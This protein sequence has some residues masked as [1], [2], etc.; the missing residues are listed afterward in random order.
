M[1]RRYFHKYETDHDAQRGRG[2]LS[3]YHPDEQSMHKHAKTLQGDRLEKALFLETVWARWYGDDFRVGPS[4][5]ASWLDRPL[6][7]AMHKVWSPNVYLDRCVIENTDDAS[8][9]AIFDLASVSGSYSGIV[10]RK[11]AVYDL[12]EYQ[13]TRDDEILIRLSI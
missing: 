11:F 2:A 5:I 1:K 10:S 4:Y 7:F 9:Y 12:H 3:Y 13:I 8:S 6:G